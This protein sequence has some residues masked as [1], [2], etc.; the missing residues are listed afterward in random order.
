MSSYVRKG[1]FGVCLALALSPA[2]CDEGTDNKDSEPPPSAEAV[3]VVLPEAPG[4]EVTLQNCLGGCH[5]MG[6]FNQQY[7]AQEW[8]KCVDDMKALGAP[9]SDEDYMPILV[10]LVK[11][12]VPKDDSN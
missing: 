2:W 6:V 7:T 9:I 5:E 8:Q 10:Y 12:L 11:N 3:A 1:I 4:R